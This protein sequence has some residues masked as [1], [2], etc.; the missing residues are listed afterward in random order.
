MKQKEVSTLATFKD[1]L[2]SGKKEAVLQFLQEK[3]LEQGELGFEFN[4]IYYLMKENRDFWKEAVRILKQ[5]LVYDQST[6]SYALKYRDPE[7]L[8]EFFANY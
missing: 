2:A 5:R 3:S 6:W 8:G 1:V 7:I 4:H